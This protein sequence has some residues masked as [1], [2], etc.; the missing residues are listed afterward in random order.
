MTTVTRTPAQQAAKRTRFSDNETEVIEPPAVDQAPSKAAR[1]TT[2]AAVASYPAAIQ[3]LAIDASKTY[4]SLKAS[5]RSQEKTISRF[6]KADEIPGSAKLKFVLHASSDI[7]ETEEFKNQKTIMETAVKTFQSTAKESIVAIANLRLVLEKGEVKLTFIET[8]KRLCEIILVEHTPDAEMQPVV[9]FCWYYSAKEIEAQVLTYCL[10]TRD[11]ITQEF[12]R[13]LDDATDGEA[14]NAI[15]WERGEQ[16]LCK[17]L[18]TRLAP[19]VKT[20]FIDSWNAQV[21]RYRDQDIKKAITKKAKEILMADKADKIQ[22]EIDLEPS[23]S[24][25]KI[26]QLIEQK[27]KEKSSAQQKE[28]NKLREQL[29]RSAKNSD[30][31]AASSKQGASSK[32]K[33][34]K[35]K[36]KDHGKSIQ[37]TKATQRFVEEDNATSPG[38]KGKDSPKGKQKSKGQS[39]KKQKSAKRADSSNRSTQQ[40][41]R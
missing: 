23:E 6:G 15:M 24:E 21:E 37:A 10:T 4:N 35:E 14:Q 17:E 36:K 13:Q 5:I 16:E 20:I 11:A 8:L 2:E 39:G 32:K 41:R 28:I 31:G 9:K 34:E 22:S 12:K 18:S 25:K 30:R 33:Q 26:F 7:M 3:S 1:F 38:R 27:V 29:Q 19:L 40:R